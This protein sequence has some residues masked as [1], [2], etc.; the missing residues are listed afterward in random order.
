MTM[1]DKALN[2]QARLQALQEWSRRKK[3]AQALD[4]R[5]AEWAEQLKKLKKAVD[6]LDW[7]GTE[8]QALAQHQPQIILVRGLVAQA[9]Q[10]L[11]DGGTDERLTHD[12][13]WAKTLAATEKLV[14]QLR[15]AVASGWKALVTDLGDFPLPAEIEAT[16]PFSRPG[17]RE[18]FSA[19]ET[20]HE[21]YQRLAR[22]ERPGTW[23]EVAAIRHLTDRLREQAARFNFAEVPEAV[24]RFFAAI[25]SGKGAPLSL[26]TDEVRDWLE[27]EGQAEAFMIVSRA[28]R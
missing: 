12:N 22:T 8:E 7:I 25:A 23:E 15:A 4:H 5:R 6:Q 13:Q 9:A 20:A 17:N 26:L 2:I 19:Y 10:I 27:T 3:D 18:A 16:L 24:G 14:S 21:Q 11:V 28:S 1:I